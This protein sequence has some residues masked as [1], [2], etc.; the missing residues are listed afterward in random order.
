MD[1]TDK[2]IVATTLAFAMP[3][4][5]LAIIFKVKSLKLGK[6]IQ[7]REQ[8]LDL[9]RMAKTANTEEERDRWVAEALSMWDILD[10]KKFT[11]TFGK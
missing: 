1:K 2:T 5:A 9:L 8:I 7:L 4:A 10:H 3:L 11:E 6:K